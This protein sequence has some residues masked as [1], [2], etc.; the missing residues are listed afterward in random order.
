MSDDRRDGI[1]RREVLALGGAV[2]AALLAEGGL[3]AARVLA[4][5]PELPQIPRRV[6]GKTGKK[7]PILLMGGDSGF[8]KVFDPRLA[9]GLRFGLDYVDAADCYAGGTCETSLG[10]FLKRANARD[11]MWITSKS[12]AHDPAGFV[13]TVDQS[14]ARLG[15]TYVDLMF[16][17]NLGDAR[18]LNDE[19]AAT[20]SKLKGEGKIRHF[21]FSTHT[22][23]VVEMLHLAAKTPWVE[24]VMF[25]YNFRKYGD[26]ELNAAMDAAHRAGV[27]LIAM[28]TQGSEAERDAWKQFQQNG[29]WTKHQAVLKS[30]WSDARI[31]A[32]VSNMDT[33]EKLRQNIAAAVD[34]SDLTAAEEHELQRYAALTRSLACDGCDQHCGA[35]LREHAGAQAGEVRIADTLRYLMYHDTYGRAGRARELFAALP[36]PA[37]NLARLDF[38][39]A[40]RACPHGVDVAALMSRAA[41]VL[42]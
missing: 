25:R 26:K 21:G 18:R 38:A 17:H 42:S 35:A 16:L 36:E 20:V 5:E 2:S 24:A 10:A 9:E 27:G 33:L 34:K 13:K 28:K 30:V 23:N 41:S 11:K 29:R 7:I 8:D 4:A 40:S 22:G 14:L 3:G 19:L 32:A 31:S 39:P 12:D 1:T 6:L 15:T 37:R